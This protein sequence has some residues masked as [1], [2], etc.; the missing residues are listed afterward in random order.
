LYGSQT[1]ES[2]GIFNVGAA[3]KGNLE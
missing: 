1:G 3:V 2:Y